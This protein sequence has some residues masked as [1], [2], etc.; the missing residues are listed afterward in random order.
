MDFL[1]EGISDGEDNETEEERIAREAKEEAERE[2]QRLRR[3]AEMDR[4]REERLAKKKAEEERWYPKQQRVLELEEYF[5]QHSLLLPEG[6]KQEF[7]E[8][9]PKFAELIKKD[10]NTMKKMEAVKDEQGL[11]SVLSGWYDRLNNLTENEMDRLNE[12]LVKFEKQVLGALRQR[13]NIKAADSS[14]RVFTFFEQLIERTLHRKMR[15]ITADEVQKKLR[16]KDLERR[17]ITRE[18]S[19]RSLESINM[20]DLPEELVAQ[21]ADLSFRAVGQRNRGASS[22]PVQFRL[23]RPLRQEVLAQFADHFV[24][25]NPSEQPNQ[26]SSDDEEDDDDDVQ[27]V[28]RGDIPDVIDW[29]RDTPENRPKSINYDKATK[30]QREE[31]R[32]QRYRDARAKSVKFVDYKSP[33]NT[34]R[35]FMKPNGYINRLEDDGPR[36]DFVDLSLKDAQEVLAKIPRPL[37]A[38]HTYD[39]DMNNPSYAGQRKLTV[40]RDHEFLQGYSGNLLGRFWI[41]RKAYDPHDDHQWETHSK[42]CCS[43]LLHDYDKTDMN[44]LFSDILEREYKELFRSN[45]RRK[46]PRISGQREQREPMN[47]VLLLTDWRL[48][49]LEQEALINA[50]VR[51]MPTNIGNAFFESMTAYLVEL[52]NDPNLEIHTII[53]AFGGSP[54]F[55]KK[56]FQKF[57]QKLIKETLKSIDVVWTAQDWLDGLD[58]VTEEDRA[59][60]TDFNGYVKK[61][62]DIMRETGH[63]YFAYMDWFSSICFFHCNGVYFT[64]HKRKTPSYKENSG[65]F[66]RLCDIFPEARQ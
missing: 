23:P 52:I 55:K 43:G 29:S 5:E 6:D 66:P 32:R 44:I 34:M 27:V 4:A 11:K 41:I 31:H 10:A 16:Q 15:R 33:K 53:F 38:W 28:D 2:E 50:S 65:R 17:A 19:R 14:Q 60:L 24:P 37:V 3:N 47:G 40:F 22:E 26:V 62:F 21:L 49:F 48:F 13:I 18:E 35:I 64:N 39:P 51:F 9:L 25:I 7:V 30:T 59:Q 56:A 57:W 42:K 46:M 61:I 8:F 12:W 20:P 36:T 1:F 45:R 58:N 54:N 63:R